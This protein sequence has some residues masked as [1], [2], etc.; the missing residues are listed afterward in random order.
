MGLPEHRGLMSALCREHFTTSS[1]YTTYDVQ[2]VRAAGISW[3]IRDTCPKLTRLLQA[4]FARGNRSRMSKIPLNLM[5][6]GPGRRG[7]EARMCDESDELTKFCTA[8]R[9]HG[10]ERW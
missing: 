5:F 1:E 10:F 3:Q 4:I 9:H 6:T 8:S 7:L 2:A